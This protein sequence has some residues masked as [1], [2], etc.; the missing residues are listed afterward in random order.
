MWATL[1]TWF[2][3]TQ[4]Q[5]NLRQFKKISLHE[6]HPTL[7]EQFE[8]S[9]LSWFARKVYKYNFKHK[10]HHIAT[11]LFPDW[12]IYI[13]YSLCAGMCIGCG[14]YIFLF[15]MYVNEDEANLWLESAVLSF[16]LTYTI[17]NPL[18]IVCRRGLLPIVATMYLDKT[19]IFERLIDAS[20][21]VENLTQYGMSAAVVGTAGVVKATYTPRQLGLLLVTKEKPRKSKVMPI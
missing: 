21:S 13:I 15:I 12:A 16:F 6:Q 9:K 3:L 20:T 14:F 5:K 19:D 2:G 11:P 10:S 4:K 17:F 8:V 18:I 7:I 1:V